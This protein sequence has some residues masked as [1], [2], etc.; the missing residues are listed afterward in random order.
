MQLT[1]R[2]MHFALQGAIVLALGVFLAMAGPFGTYGDLAPLP[3]Y[4]YWVGLCLFGY[5]SVVVAAHAMRA[6]RR[7]SGALALGAVA[8]ASALP[9]TF[10]VAWAEQLLRL[11]HAVPLQVM[12][13]VYGSVAAIQLLMVLLLT[14]MRLSLE[15]LLIVHAAVPPPSQAPDAAAAEAPLAGAAPPPFLAR[16]PAHLGSDL[17]ALQAEDHYLRVI[18]SAG[19]DLVLVRLADAL[20]ELPESAGMQV[21]R[22]WWV[23]FAAVTAVE[24]EPGRMYLRLANGLQVPVSRTYQAAVRVARWPAA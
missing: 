24:R 3:R 18:T 9:T 10:A 2:Q 12:P 15:P 5:G 19:S 13:R 17:L 6:L 16:V 4:G 8:L 7:T 11:D 23:G 21:H 22:S 14:R 1:H 20:R